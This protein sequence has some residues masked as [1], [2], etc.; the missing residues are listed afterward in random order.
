MSLRKEEVVNS[1]YMC[2]LDIVGKGK[3]GMTGGKQ[4]LKPAAKTEPAPFVNSSDLLSELIRSGRSET[5]SD[6]VS[7]QKWRESDHQSGW[8]KPRRGIGNPV[9]RCFLIWPII[10]G[11]DR[12]PRKGLRSRHFIM[13]RLANF[14]VLKF[15]SKKEF[16]D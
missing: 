3:K 13:S 7:E 12:R 6:L 2:R 11:F 8:G 1:S 5:C 16:D 4:E 10:E 9:G 15:H 14:E